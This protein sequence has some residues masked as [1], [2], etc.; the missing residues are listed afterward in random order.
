MKLLVVSADP[1]ARAALGALLEEDER[2]TLVDVVSPSALQGVSFVQNSEWAV[3]VFIWDC[4][5]GAADLAVDSFVDFATPVVVLLSEADDAGQ[6]LAAGAR[7]IIPRDMD[8]DKILG[9][10]AAVTAGL[11]AVDPAF[12]T[13]LPGLPRG[14]TDGP[15]DSITPRELQVL[16][17]LA[18]GLTNRAVANRLDVSEHTVKFHVNSILSKLD[19]QSRTEAV[20][21]ATRL[22]LIAL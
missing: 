15:G 19:A 10:A 16:Q 11:A 14:L 12:L 13:V 17:L 1:L 8:S 21:T 3:E 4:G 18:E 7:G 22:G 9:A 6:A 20:V 2:C 5:L